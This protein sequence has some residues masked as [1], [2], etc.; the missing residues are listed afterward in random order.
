MKLITLPHPHVLFTL[1][2]CVSACTHADKTITDPAVKGAYIA[3]A[4]KR[5]KSEIMLGCVLSLSFELDLDMTPLL[6]NK[7]LIGWFGRS[8]ARP[9]LS[10]QFRVEGRGAS[11]KS[12]DYARLPELI[13]RYQPGMDKQLRD[14][15]SALKAA[16]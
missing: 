2:K 3:A 13:Q 15:V 11:Y 6:A 16:L 10:K 1:D 9:L 12:P 5:Y 4:K 14:A 7:L 8:I